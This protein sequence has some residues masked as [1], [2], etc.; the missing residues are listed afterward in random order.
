MAL[1]Q[2]R[3]PPPVVALALAGAMWW[4]A[5]L[6]PRLDIALELRQ[7]VALVFGLAG[8]AISLAASIQFH[9]VHT[10]V[11]PLRPEKATQLVTGGVFR[12]SRNP[13]YVGMLLG[14]L[15]WAVYL[16]APLAVAGPALFILFIDRFQIVPEE[17]AME[18]LFGAEFDAYRARV[19][20]WL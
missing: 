7:G 14:L 8:I 9:R 17:R 6:T 19:R 3:I 20:R 16:A 12:L 15:A 1:L 11:N 10:T 4:V 13:M 2:N 5:R 18:R